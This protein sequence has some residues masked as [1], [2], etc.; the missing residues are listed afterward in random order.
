M[1]DQKRSYFVFHTSYLF[2]S[3]QRNGNNITASNII[4][5]SS[6]TSNST[7]VNEMVRTGLN[8]AAES[9]INNNNWGMM[10]GNPR[11]AMMAAFCCARAAIAAR[12]VKIK[13]RLQ[14]PS[15]TRPIKEPA[16]CIGLPRKSVKSSRLSRLM[17][18]M[19]SELKSNLASTKSPGEEME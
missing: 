2:Q 4:I 11:I 9:F 19:S 1:P 6:A 14:P 15:N 10:R 8:A 3:F 18:S 13:L 7:V 16:F 17:T 12:N 5:M